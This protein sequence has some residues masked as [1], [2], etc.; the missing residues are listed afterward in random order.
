MMELSRAA[1]TAVAGRK[2]VGRCEGGVEVEGG[3]VV[4][5]GGRKKSPHEVHIIPWNAITR[6]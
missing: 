5:G 6:C 2:R 4:K 3:V 1:E